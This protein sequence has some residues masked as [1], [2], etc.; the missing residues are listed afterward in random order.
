[1]QIPYGFDSERNPWPVMSWSIAS[2]VLELAVDWGAFGVAVHVVPATTAGEGEARIMPGAMSALLDAYDGDEIVVKLPKLPCDPVELSADGWT[3]QRPTGR[4][5][6][7]L[8][9]RR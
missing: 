3:G 6:G 5:R 8:A 7:G 1:M 2:G 9:R 4:P